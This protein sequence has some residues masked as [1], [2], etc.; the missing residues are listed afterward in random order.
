M[1]AAF[2]ARHHVREAVI[3]ADNDKPGIDGAERL[4][5]PCIST[6][7]LTPAKDIREFTALGGTRAQ[8]ESSLR[9]VIWKQP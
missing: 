9:G 7:L 5:L 1:L 3:L 2:L 4:E 6:I 8:L